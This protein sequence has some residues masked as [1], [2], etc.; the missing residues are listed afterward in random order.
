MRPYPVG[1]STS[2]HHELATTPLG[3]SV[4]CPG[5]VTTNIVNSE[6]NRPGA[7]PEEQ[8]APTYAMTGEALPADVVADEVVA[9]VRADRFWILP[10]PHYADQAIEM[11]E[12]R[13]TGA[14]R[15]GRETRTDWEMPATVP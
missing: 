9:A 14:G 6:R 2:M 11:A 8:D 5:L 15:R 12:G 13:K 3:V 7:K 4:L 1:L 10:H